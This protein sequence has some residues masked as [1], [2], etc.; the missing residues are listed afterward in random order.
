[1]RRSMQQEV[2]QIQSSII[3]Q[4]E[5]YDQGRPPR[6]ADFASDTLTRLQLD[7]STLEKQKAEYSNESDL[8]DDALKDV[9]NSGKCLKIANLTSKRPLTGRRL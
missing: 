9:E 8:V 3:E 7:R 6:V 4:L 2:T 5:E 1:M